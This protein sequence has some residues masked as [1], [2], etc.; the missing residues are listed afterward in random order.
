M[1]TRTGLIVM[2]ISSLV[3][4]GFTFWQLLPSQGVL[5]SILWGLG[6]AAAM[7]G[8]FALSYLVNVT[9]RRR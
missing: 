8:V 7:W 4:G 9:V 5:N 3:L 1:S 2:A 6:A